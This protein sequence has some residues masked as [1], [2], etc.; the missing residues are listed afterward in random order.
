MI[1]HLHFIRRRRASWLPIPRVIKERTHIIH[2][3]IANYSAFIAQFV[4]ASCL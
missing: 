2:R 1:E 3:A 4:R